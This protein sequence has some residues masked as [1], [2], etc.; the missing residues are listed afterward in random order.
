MQ[1]QLEWVRVK[2]IIHGGCLMDRERERM[3][4][5]APVSQ[6]LW[7]LSLPAMVGMFVNGLY[8]LVDTVYIGHGV[9]AMGIAGLSVAFPIQMLMGGIGAMLGI[10]AASVIS[11]SLGKGDPERAGTAFGNLLLVVSVLGIVFLVMGE[12]LTEP[13]LRSF[14]AS[15]EILVYAG[16]YM[17]IIFVGSP[18][19]F[20]CMSMNNVIRSEGAARVAMFSMMIG[21]MANIVLD[22]IFIFGLGMGIRGAALATVL[23]RCLVVIWIV[24]FYLSGKSLLTLHRRYLI[25]HVRLLGEILAVGFPALVHHA[26]T[27]FVFGLMNRTLAFYGGD[28]AISLL[29]ANNRI[30]MF[31]VMPVVGIAQGMQPI[32]GYSYGARRFER[33]VEVISRSNRLALLFCSG[34]TALLLL[35][36]GTLLRL[37]LSDPELLNEGSLALRMMVAGFFLAGYNKVAGSIFQALGKPLPSF[38]LNTARPILI[39]V[40]LL[41]MLPRFIGA[42]GVWLSFALA[43][44]LTFLVTLLFVVPQKR[45]LASGRGTV[46]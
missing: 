39:F 34:V 32:L 33:S 4:A 43:D 8:N 9:G 22:P 28:L 37:F 27:S 45:A 14:G 25:P 44:V 7:K 46:E 35:F 23:A 10:G 41:L 24:R 3:L 17:R 36:P 21:A 5:S 29:G 19:I 40:P 2:R 15:G 31:S 18:L 1:I 20:F 6:L 16:P 38:I 26:S 12:I 13:I 42:N 30:I 11:R